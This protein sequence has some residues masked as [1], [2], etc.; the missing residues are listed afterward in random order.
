[1][2]E[3]EKPLKWLR[4][5]EGEWRWAADYLEQALKPET[6]KS[7]APNPIN[8]LKTYESVVSVIRQL[9]TKQPELVFKLQGNIRQR[10]YRSDSNG[11]KPLTFTLSNET[12]TKLTSLA[13]RNKVSEA[14]LI[15]ALIAQEGETVEAQKNYDKQ[16]K[17]AV[18]LERKSGQ[19]RA[20]HL[21]DQL[22]EALKHLERCLELLARWEL[23]WPDDK[24]PAASDDDIKKLVEPRMKELKDALDYLAFRNS[25]TTQRYTEGT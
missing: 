19:Q 8:R 18:A 25:L 1:M 12:I 3:H 16:L 9:Q 20:A 2:S 10:R 11:R 5:Q 15:S 24:P 13:R 4:K 7:L 22:D 17:N 21:T 6:I 23:M 14:A